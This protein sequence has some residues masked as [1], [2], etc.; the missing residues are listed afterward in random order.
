MPQP[1]QR[2]H[3]PATRPTFDLPP[4]DR[5]DAAHWLADLARARLPDCQRIVVYLIDGSD[6][7]LLLAAA[8]GFEPGVEAG[9]PDRVSRKQAENGTTVAYALWQPAPCWLANPKADDASTA[10]YACLPFSGFGQRGVLLA[11]FDSEALGRHV[12][13]GQETLL[14]LAATVLAL[15]RER[16][17]ADR[18]EQRVEALSME[19]DQHRRQAL[20]SWNSYPLPLLVS[21]R[22][23]RILTANHQL[24]EL[25]GLAEPPASVTDVLPNAEEPLARTLAEP[26]RCL[27]WLSPRLGRH[28][29]AVYCRAQASTTH[30][31]SIAC[32]P[33]DRV[34]AQVWRTPTLVEERLMIDAL[35]TEAHLLRPRVVLGEDL[36]YVFRRSG[37]PSIRRFCAAIGLSELEWSTLRQ[38]PEPIKNV[39]VCLALRLVDGLP[40]LL[41]DIDP[42]QA[43]ERIRRQTGCRITQRE[44]ALVLGRHGT[45]F[46]HWV[47]GE[48]TLPGAAAAYLGMILRVLEVRPDSW[49]L[50]RQLAEIEARAR[51]IDSLWSTGTWRRRR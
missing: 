49:A 16:E 46:S 42:S 3:P 12:L 39:S 7:H 13:R 14:W 5:Q 36:E 19:R 48:A 26:G 24:L 43:L 22:Q 10:G 29:G 27:D 17:R 44:F 18:A 34:A 21:D 23:G 45:A 30:L 15:G 47:R 32:L 1:R 33:L 31:V 35:D 20:E 6:R 41:D 50:F 8:S 2:T 28:L 25:G 9:L 51:G 11:A 40:G 38:Q 37:L 4:T